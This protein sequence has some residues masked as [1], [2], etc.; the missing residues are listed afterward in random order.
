MTTLIMMMMVMMTMVMMRANKE[1]CTSWSDIDLATL[2]HLA[3]SLDSII[4]VIIIIFFVII[5]SEET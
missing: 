3:T 2:D 1:E 5:T 4:I